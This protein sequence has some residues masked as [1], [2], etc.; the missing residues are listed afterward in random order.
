[1]GKLFGT[2]GI[3]GVAGEPPLDPWTVGKVGRALVAL[4]EKRVLVGRDTRVSGPWIESAL[5]QAMRARGA[6]VASAGVITT[7]GVAYLTRQAGFDCGVMISASH[8]PF[9]DNGIKV[10]SGDGLKLSD[11]AEERLES[12]ILTDPSP[13][14]GD[15][16]ED[17]GTPPLC[18]SNPEF[19][20]RYIEFLESPLSRG[21]LKGVRV[22][23][24]C[25]NGAAHAIAPEVFGRL[26]ADVVSLAN[27]PDGRN[28]NA[29]CGA[30]HPEGMA[31]SV[32]QSGSLF[33]VAFDGDADRAI[34]A[35]ERGNVVDGDFVLYVL[36][37]HFKKTGR[38][39]SGSVV[40]TV[41]AN[42]GLEV[43]LQREG[44]GM[45]RTQVGDRYVLEAMLR[46]GHELGGEQ[47]GHTII[48]SRSKAGD[49][50]LTALQVAEILISE[51][52]PLSQLRRGLEKFPQVLLN[53]V[54]RQKPDFSV[55]PEIQDRIDDAAAS[56]GNRGRVVIRYSGTEPLARVMV[57]GEKEEEIQA[58][59]GA[60]AE[61]FQRS[62]G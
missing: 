32:A 30:L 57:E 38:L 36:A 50:I 25:A 17:L 13:N 48:L 62:L 24:D 47:S 49:G 14:G 42:I 34:L 3:R 46:G 28:I 22:M 33:G 40:T 15:H 54:V 9:A 8:N 7:P 56:L 51:G 43:A 37:L 53:V 52:R 59:A 58:W 5:S 60:I 6:S 35:D 1:M 20:E 44:I 19:S 11:Q 31:K 16:D 41:M 2:D 10:F 18:F 45:V 61:S 23:L 29:G 27:Q 26:G 12:L 21:A 4:G 55:I 39:A